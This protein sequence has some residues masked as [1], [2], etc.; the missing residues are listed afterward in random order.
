[1]RRQTD[2]HGTAIAEQCPAVP[3]YISA[4]RGRLLA[5]DETR[6]ICTRS[7]RGTR[8]AQVRIISEN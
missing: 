2:R 3:V 4:E 8:N 5:A 1:M 6:L 7:L